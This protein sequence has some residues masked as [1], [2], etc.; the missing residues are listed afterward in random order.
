MRKWWRLLAAVWLGRHGV[1][2]W[3]M[4]AIRDGRDLPGL[5]SQRNCLPLAASLLKSNNPVLELSEQVIAVSELKKR[6]PNTF[7]KAANCGQVLR[8][9]LDPKQW[10]D[11]GNVTP[12]K[13]MESEEEEE[14]EV[15]SFV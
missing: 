4:K 11:F 7:F 1:V 10:P 6:G 14:E 8:V 9:S 3:C 2:V 5:R 12:V 15:L 13:F